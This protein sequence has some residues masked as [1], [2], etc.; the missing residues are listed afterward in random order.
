MTLLATAASDIF[1]QDLED[2]PP[3]VAQSIE[4]KAD[5]RPPIQPP[6]AKE[7]SKP[8]SQEQPDVTYKI[9]VVEKIDSN[10]VKKKD[11]SGT[12]DAL[13]ILAEGG[14]VGKIAGFLPAAD[15][16]RKALESGSSV[17]VGFI[18]DKWGNK[19]GSAEVLK[20]EE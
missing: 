20:G 3:E 10:P 14:W 15:V 2:L 1:T 7:P 17:K 6:K 16:L 18:T 12:F 9:I 19:I 4:G 11:G 13:T 5:A 8:E